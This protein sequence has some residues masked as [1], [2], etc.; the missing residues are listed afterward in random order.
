MARHAARGCEVVLSLQDADRLQRTVQEATGGP[1]PCTT[2]VACP[3]LPQEPQL[4]RRG[5][6]KTLPLAGLAAAALFGGWQVGCQMLEALHSAVIH[7]APAV[8]V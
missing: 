7:L 5:T 2:G 8:G 6:R 1:C 3:L 4:V